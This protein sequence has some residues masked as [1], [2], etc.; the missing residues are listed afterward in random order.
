MDFTEMLMAH[1]DNGAAITIATI[2]VGDRE[3]PEFGILKTD[4]SNNITSF[5]E[6]KTCYLNCLRKQKA[7]PQILVKK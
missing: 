1:Q 7:K 4:S 2:P 5:I 3:A 6:I